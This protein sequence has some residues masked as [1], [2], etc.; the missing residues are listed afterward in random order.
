MELAP[1][2][3]QSNADGL[4]YDCFLSCF[5][6]F[7]LL[8]RQKVKLVTLFLVPQDAAG[9][10]RTSRAHIGIG[11]QNVANSTIRHSNELVVMLRNVRVGE[12]GGVGG[13]PTVALR[14]L[15][16]SLDCRTAGRGSSAL[17]VP[18]SSL[19][20]AKVITFN[21]KRTAAQRRGGGGE[22]E[23]KWERK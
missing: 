15:Y 11:K 18:I 2:T 21:M 4:F 10:R 1:A 14:L 19:G 17:C 16:G 20:I 12:E 6:F 23:R 13:I 22:R 9:R 7:F 8:P 5:F 3:F